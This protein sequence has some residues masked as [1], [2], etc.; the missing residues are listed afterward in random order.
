[1]NPKLKELFSNTLIFTL[2]NFSSKILVFLM[3]PLYTAVLTTEEY[4]VSD[5]VNT[6]GNL[7]LPFLSLAISNAV[8]RFC[9]LQEY[10]HEDVFTIGHRVVVYGTVV[11]I[12]ITAVFFFFNIFDQLG[13]YVWFVPAYF[14]FHAYSNLLSYYSRGVGEVRISAIAGVANTFTTVSL[15]LVLLL[16]FKLGILGYMVSYLVG[17]FVSILVM[18]LRL[19]IGKR[20]RKECNSFLW[21]QMM[22][23]S[24]PLIPNS[25]SWWALSSF[26]RFLIL[27]YLGVSAVGVYSASEKIPAILTAI[28]AVFSEAWM[29]SA[30]NGYGTEET[31]LFIRKVHRILFA[32]L[33]VVT[34]GGI[35]AAKPVASLL[36]S[37]DFS[38]CWYLIPFLMIGVFMG[39]MVG[40]YGSLYSAQRQNGMMF[41][42]TMVGALVAVA[43]ILLMLKRYGIIVAALANMIGYFIIWFMRKEGVKSFF[44]LQY[45]TIRCIIQFVL[46]VAEAVLV[47]YSLWIL[48]SI[49]LVF[50]FVY[51]GKELYASIGFLN[52][53]IKERF[54]KSKVVS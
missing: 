45:S 16:V 17:S 14:L 41:T 7:L 5:M 25:L 9:F 47:S 21:K 33:A 43:V 34:G 30:L 13:V 51:N 54:L 10:D 12:L 46:L 38:S 29:L 27:S 37:G 3:V 18:Y 35:L 15:N 11:S 39:S 42:S 4:G 1:M 31:A 36:L 2:A 50:I 32:L 53:F 26:S 52:G 24:L 20:I 8:L 40:F 6:V 19:S 28:F 44:N 22:K 48:A 23:F 49:V